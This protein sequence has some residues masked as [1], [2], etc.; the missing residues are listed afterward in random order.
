MQLYHCNVGW[1]IVDEGSEILVPATAVREIHDDPPGDYRRLGQPERLG[2]ERVYEQ[3]V[4]AAADGRV[5]VALVNRRRALG[6]V[7]RYRREQLPIHN[8]WRMPAEGFYTVGLEPATNRDSGRWE[9][10][11]RGE[12]RTI[13]PG[14]VR[15]YDL[16][17]EVLTSAAEIDAVAAEVAAIPLA[18]DAS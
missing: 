1:P 10:R 4:A 17:L 8:V 2:V 5:T 15:P 9:A 16:D 7:Q 11:A 6:L 12:L 18:G 3:E 13:E 14:E